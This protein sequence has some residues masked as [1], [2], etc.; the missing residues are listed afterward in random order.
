M[1]N[2]ILYDIV[3]EQDQKSQPSETDGYFWVGK[4]PDGGGVFDGASRFEN[5]QIPQGTTVNSAILRLY[6]AVVGSGSG[7]LNIKAYGID[8]DNT[9][10]FT[11]NPFGRTRTSAS[12]TNHDIKPSQGGWRDLDVTAQVNEILAR[13]GWSSGNAMGFLVFDDGS[14]DNVYMLNYMSNILLIRTSALPDFTPTPINISAPT[15]PAAS[16]YGIRV[17]QPGVDVKTATE[18]QLYFTSRKK[19]FRVLAEGDKEDGFFAHGLSYAPGVLGFWI[20]GDG[21]RQIANYPY[22]IIDVGVAVLSD[23]TNVYSTVPMYVYVFIDP[24]T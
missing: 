19:E 17:S 24:L 4:Y 2:H 11:T 15:F 13:G 22:T 10:L 5:I 14:P 9:A 16:S 21:N 1:A 12:T 20:D 7:N 18:S 23:G 6:V 8:E 3:Q